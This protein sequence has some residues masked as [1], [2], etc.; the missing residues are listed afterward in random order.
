MNVFC[1]Q[2]PSRD[3]AFR[4]EFAFLLIHCP[5]CATDDVSL[6]RSTITCFAANQGCP[7]AQLLGLRTSHAICMA[8]HFGDVPSLLAHLMDKGAMCLLQG[9]SLAVTRLSHFLCDD[10]PSF[11]CRPSVP[12]RDPSLQAPT[13]G[14][15][16][17]ASYWAARRPSRPRSPMPSW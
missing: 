1:A 3:G 11:H 15:R 7:P 6:P 5:G 16:P 13:C 14:I 12:S 9:T 2:N 8:D 4:T 10:H 17:I